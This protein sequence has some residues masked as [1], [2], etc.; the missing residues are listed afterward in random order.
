MAVEY[1]GAINLPDV[2]HDGDST[3]QT[4]SPKDS[5]DAKDGNDQS[6]GCIGSE[7]VILLEKAPE[8]RI[9]VGV[10]QISNV[11]SDTSVHQDG[12]NIDHSE[13]CTSVHQD[14]DNIDHSQLC[15]GAGTL[16][17]GSF[18]ESQDANVKVPTILVEENF[19]AKS[20]LTDLWHDWKDSNFPKVNVSENCVKG[21]E[22]LYSNITISV[23]EVE[24]A[25]TE[26]VPT[27]YGQ[28]LVSDTPECFPQSEPSPALSNADGE[29]TD[30]FVATEMGDSYIEDEST[31]SSFVTQSGQLYRVDLL[32]EIIEDA[33]NN[34][35]TG[36]RF[37]FWICKIIRCSLG[38]RMHS[39]L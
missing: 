16:E 36:P 27:G 38:N 22:E 33:K 12:D 15:T 21:E 10:S 2:A 14:D 17:L 18:N 3:C 6:S 7:E 37:E 26:V 11:M 28:E 13:L 30:G 34:K 25:V 31:F 32:E 5:L 23:S 35:V 29:K 9:E 39:L 1:L 19:G 8:N 20:S 24:N 4:I